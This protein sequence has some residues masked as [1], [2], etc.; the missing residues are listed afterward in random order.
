MRD[1]ETGIAIVKETIL[2]TI[3]VDMNLVNK[4]QGGYYV[5]KNNKQICLN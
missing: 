5:D 2:E 3:V 4:T 1:Q